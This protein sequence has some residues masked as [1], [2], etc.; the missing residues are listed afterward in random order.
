MTIVTAMMF[1]LGIIPNIPTESFTTTCTEKVRIS[2]ILVI[3][4][5]ALDGLNFVVGTIL[6][7][8]L[9]R[10]SKSRMSSELRIK[11]SFLSY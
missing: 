1:V 11:I 7:I 2:S 10:D 9:K 3:L 8:T 6:L 4:R 5:K